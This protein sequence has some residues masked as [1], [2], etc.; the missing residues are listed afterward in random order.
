VLDVQS[1]RAPDSDSH[2]ILLDTEVRDRLSVIKRATQKSYLGIFELKQLN[3]IKIAN[4]CM[5]F[6]NTF[7]VLGNVLDRI[8]KQMEENIDK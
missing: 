7:L 4:V 3:Y 6:K 1:F 5:L 8:A 2:Q